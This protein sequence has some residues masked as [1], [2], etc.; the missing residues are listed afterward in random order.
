MIRRLH[1]SE[2][3]LHGIAAMIEHGADCQ[4]VVQQIVAV[5]ASLRQVTGLVV[6]HHL[7]ACLE[8]QLHN[9]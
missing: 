8:E 6:K 7:S 9:P 3:H 1:C 2:G 4:R 5:Q